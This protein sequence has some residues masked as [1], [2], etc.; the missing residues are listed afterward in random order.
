MAVKPSVIAASRWPQVAGKA[1]TPA[2]RTI[3]ASTPLQPASMET[4]NPET[5]SLKTLPLLMTVSSN[6][7]ITDAAIHARNVVKGWITAACT[8]LSSSMVKSVIRQAT[9]MDRNLNT[10]RSSE[11]RRVV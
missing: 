11:V 5:E 8:G 7:R 4:A 10:L 2:M 9:K 3:E 6:G 1:K